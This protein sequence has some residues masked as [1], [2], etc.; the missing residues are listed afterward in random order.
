MFLLKFFLVIMASTWMMRGEATPPEGFGRFG[1]INDDGLLTMN[2]KPYEASIPSVKGDFTIRFASESASAEVLDLSFTGKSIQLTGAGEGSPSRVNYTLLYPGFSL[3]YDSASPDFILSG[4]KMKAEM[5]P[6]DG[7]EYHWIL[8]IPSR[9]DAVPIAVAFKKG[10]RPP[11]YTLIDKSGSQQLTLEGCEAIGE[12][13]IFTPMGLQTISSSASG[14]EMQDLRNLCDKWAEIMIPKLKHRAFSFNAAAGNVTITDH[15]TSQGKTISPIPPVL[16][17]ALQK[18]YTAQIMGDLVYPDCLTKYGPFA[19]IEGL[20]AKYTL[21]LPPLEERGYIKRPADADRV[22]L[23]NDLVGHLPEVWRK[24]AVDLGYAGVANAQLV[25]PWLNEKNR[26]DVKNSWTTYLPL[27]FKMP[28]Y[29]P[30][31]PRETWKVETEPFSDLEYIW[32]YFIQ[33]PPPQNFK[34]D[35]DWGNALPLYGIYKYAQYSGDWDFV[36]ENW[37]DVKR[38]FRYF[39]FGDDWAWMTVVN[40]DM[41]WSTGTGD[42]MASVFCGYLACYK[43]A[44]AIGDF[45]MEEYFAYKLARVTVPCV[46]R[47]WYNDWAEEKGL[48]PTY[49]K[50]YSI[51]GFWEKD[52]FTYSKMDQQYTDPWGPTNVLSADGILPE[53]FYAFMKFNPDGLQ[54]F[55]NDY[56][57]YYPDWAN[58]NHEYPFSTIY[59]GNSVYVTFPHIYA[60]A[61]LGEPSS[62][63]WNY[64]DSA[65]TNFGNF[66]FVGPIVIAEILSRET[67]MYLTEWQPA[68]YSDGVLSADGKT[69]TLYFD[70]SEQQEWQFSAYL[71]GDSQPLQVEINGKEKPFQVQG[72]ELKVT[73]QAQGAVEV[74]IT[75]Q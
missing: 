12:V 37:D 28:P 25:W 51:Q 55:E 48:I 68:G 27:A 22:Q 57:Q 4:T 39:D 36:E 32:T 47:F 14:T 44:R 19:Y 41:G 50:E 69:V 7:R 40:G 65:K 34:L 56:E 63:L 38:V 24:N 75:F 33:G 1:S 66:H 3:V 30:D 11:S 21:P 61:M 60:R 45:E 16:A 67:T 71:V 6:D 49:S 74:V 70:L 58:G 13:R 31:Y 72:N 8:L 23:L 26:T 46:S 73:T 2:V 20:E 59:D 17:F 43:M 29:E 35:I 53:L 15:F 42:P 54:E 10:F 52:T 62:T 9:T 18:E 5:S 64:V